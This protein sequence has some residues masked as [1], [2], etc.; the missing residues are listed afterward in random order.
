MSKVKI[1]KIELQ[2]IHVKLHI[3]V[4]IGLIENITKL[5]HLFTVNMAF[6]KNPPNKIAVNICCFIIIRHFSSQSFLVSCVT[7]YYT[8]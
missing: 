2:L 3:I 7:T 4:L 6:R 8:C 5:S 1:A